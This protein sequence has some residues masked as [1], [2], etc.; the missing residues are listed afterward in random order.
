MHS[1]SIEITTVNK[2]KLRSAVS[3][4]NSDIFG[5]NPNSELSSARKSPENQ[6]AAIDDFLEVAEAPREDEEECSPNE[7]ND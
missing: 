3:R 2:E 4:L 5:N 7:R 6:F 1:Q